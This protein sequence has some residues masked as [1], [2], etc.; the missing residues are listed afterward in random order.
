[1]ETYREKI[2]VVKVE[3][4]MIVASDPCYERD[5]WCALSFVAENG[6]YKIESE[7]EEESGRV[8]VLRAIHED[9]VGKSLDYAYVNC[10]AVDS[11]TFGIFDYDYHKQTHNE[12]N[13][14]LEVD[15][16]WYENY[17]VE[18]TDNYH[19]VD[20][21]CVISSSGYGDGTYA[22][23][24]AY[25][26]DEEIIAVEVVFIEDNDDYINDED[27]LDEMDWE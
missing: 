3:S 27:E 8:A 24:V 18:M 15:D 12:G 25:N 5:V 4:G 22:L 13:E 10:V 9:Y 11:G 26:D 7:I 21:K 14:N 19:I 1:M 16:E 20:D 6:R 23:S 17:V 2:G